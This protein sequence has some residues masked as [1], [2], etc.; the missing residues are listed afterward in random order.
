[1]IPVSSMSVTARYLRQIL[2][3]NITDVNVNNIYI[4]NPKDLS[5]DTTEQCLNLFFY[6]VDYSGYPADGTPDNPFYVKMFCLITALGADTTEGEGENQETIT[7]GEND[8]RLIGEV[9]HVLHENPIIQLAG[10]GYPL[11]LQSSRAWA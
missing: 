9:I 3:D 5:V 7:A 2:A 1:M 11:H 10:E 4:S 6:R 8:L